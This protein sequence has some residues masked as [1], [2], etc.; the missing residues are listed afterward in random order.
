L[1]L[2]GKPLGAKTRAVYLVID[3]AQRWYPSFLDCATEAIRQQASRAPSKDTKHNLTKQ[4]PRRDGGTVAAQ[5]VDVDIR[6][7]C[8]PALGFSNQP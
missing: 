5:G 8:A 2:G 1:L 7:T 6:F 4:S 3:G